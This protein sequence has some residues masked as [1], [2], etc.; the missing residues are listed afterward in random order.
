[1]TLAKCGLHIIGG[2]SGSLGKPRITK[3]VDCSGEY[4][5][6]VRAQVGDACTIV[7]R[8]TEREQPLDD[9]VRRA[10]EW[11]SKRRLAMWDSNALYEGYNEV[12]D[13]QA[14][15]YAAFEVERLRLMHEGG[16]RSAVG[17]WSVGTPDLPVWTTY[18]P[19]LDAMNAGDAVSLHE[20]YADSGDV[21]NPW[22]VG[23]YRMVPA[24]VN[25][26]IIIT[27][28]G[29]DSVEGKGY[30]GWKLAG[31]SANAYLAELRAQ[32]VIYDKDANVLGWT[33][34]TAGDL[35]Q[36]A[37]FGVN[38]LA[39]IIAAEATPPPTP[40]P[41]TPT[42]RK[43]LH[44]L[45][46]SR[47]SQPFGANPAYYAKYGIR[48]HNGQDMAVPSTCDV[49]QWHGAP[50]VA[51]HAGKAII[52]R[53]DPSYGNYVYNWGTWCDTL[54]AHLAEGSLPASG[55]VREGDLIGWVG[56]TGNCIPSG[57]HGTHLH[58]GLRL[59]PYNLT[60]GYRGY[61]DPTPFLS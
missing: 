14:P 10:Q 23:R 30:P 13:S 53:D 61:V 1:M 26:P 27:E 9:P 55:Q 19:V 6:Q 60:N 44:P 15:Q 20:Y 5:R 47:V 59:K 17:S 12:A 16:R 28:A 43:L 11:Y 7:V 57:I 31:I 34:F 51:A 3:L 2:Y 25:K 8:W 24:L 39:P 22:H 37:N 56:Y 36:W 4:I 54:Y 42:V 52:V 48:A 58:F 29:R 32:G 46:W 40:T 45:I 50:V 35:G 38:E 41:G 18:Q 33:V 21:T 49:F